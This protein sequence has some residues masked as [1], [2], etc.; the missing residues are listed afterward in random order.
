VSSVADKIADALRR[1][2]RPVTLRRNSYS[3]ATPTPTDVTVYAYVKGAAP[4]E[5]IGKLKQFKS[6]VVI[7]NREIAAATWPGPPKA[8]DFLVIDGRPR[9][10]VSV[11]PKYLGGEILV[12]AINV[13]GPA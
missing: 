8:D 9:T 11:E 7:S 13:S 3:G 1:F 4:S 6:D 2:G 5:L 10:V 12:Y